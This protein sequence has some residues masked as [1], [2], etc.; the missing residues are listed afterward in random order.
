MELFTEQE[1]KSA[2]WNDVLKCEC[3]MCKAIFYKTKHSIYNARERKCKYIFC[4]RACVSR[5]T[6][7]NRGG[8]EA[9]EKHCETCG[10][11]FK[12]LVCHSK[13]TKHD[14]CCYSCF[15][16][17]INAH[18]KYGYNRSKLENYIDEKLIKLYP[19]ME[20]HFNR[21][22]AINGELD[23]F[24]PSLKLAF[25]LNGIFHYEPI[26]GNDKLKSTKNN[27]CRKFQACLERGI[28]LCVIDT[29]AQK[30]FKE[31]TSKK[32][33]D[34]IVKIIEQK[35]VPVENVDFSYSGYEP[36][37][38]AEGTGKICSYGGA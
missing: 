33:L 13:K 17:Y 11:V 19:K 35:L 30:Y 31:N 24:I 34:I 16:I 28:E 1:Y 7:L 14:F 18:K 25:E 4:S 32:Y 38:L 3:D 20:F 37:I 12:K 29:S 15:G 6:C 36:K 8:H 5:K 2:R 9:E 10:K 21:N 23:I 22:D 26:F 27:D